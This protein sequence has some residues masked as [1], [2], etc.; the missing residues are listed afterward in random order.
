MALAEGRELQSMPEDF[1]EPTNIPKEVP[2][3]VKQEA[4]EGVIPAEEFNAPMAVKQDVAEAEMS[5]EQIIE[6]V[7]KAIQETLKEQ[8]LTAAYEEAQKKYGDIWLNSSQGIVFGFRKLVFADLE[9]MQGITTLPE[10]MRYVTDNCV[11]LNKE[12][13]LG[14]TPSA[15]VYEMVY[16]LVRQVSQA[17]PDIPFSVKL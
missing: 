4:L 13:L 3:P 7:R 12:K 14:P 9:A 15:Y 10:E 16:N 6:E 2:G 8:G 1:R 17:T 11:I 5:D